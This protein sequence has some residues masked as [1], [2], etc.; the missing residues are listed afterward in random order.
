MLWLHFEILLLYAGEG[1]L[2]LFLSSYVHVVG[3]C[4]CTSWF[5]INSIRNTGPIKFKLMQKV[6]DVRRNDWNKANQNITE[7]FSWKLQWPVKKKQHSRKRYAAQIQVICFIQEAVVLFS[8]IQPNALSSM[9]LVPSVLLFCSYYVLLGFSWSYPFTF[10]PKI[11]SKL[12]LV[13]W[14]KCTHF[15]MGIKSITIGWV[16]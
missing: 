2:L 14:G 12:S 6:C 15:G 9:A 13:L 4:A 11:K 5:L 8:Y 3:S 16:S 1:P 10:Y 7:K